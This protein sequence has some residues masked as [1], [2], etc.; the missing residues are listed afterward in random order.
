LVSKMRQRSC[1][2]RG[3]TPAPPHHDT[4]C[5]GAL[6]NGL[7]EAS[8]APDRLAYT[9][10]E[11]CRA[12]T[13]GQSLAYAEIAAGRLKVVRVGRRTLVPVDAA[14]A[15]LASL[16][17]GVAGEPAAPRRARLARQRTDKSHA[18]CDGLAP[19]G[20]ST[21]AV[22]SGTPGSKGNR[23][24]VPVDNSHSQRWPR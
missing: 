13:I 21:L 23:A 16:P 3:S 17:E 12:V 5:A 18:D 4:A 15:W 7:I 8:P 10:D 2:T 20:P 22:G 24:R 19:L 1:R 6:I 9:I 11:F 14:K